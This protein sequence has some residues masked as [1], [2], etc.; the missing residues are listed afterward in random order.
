MAVIHSRVTNYNSKLVESEPKIPVYTLREEQT[1]KVISLLMQGCEE[2]G[3]GC[4]DGPPRDR[5]R[6][7]RHDAHT[8]HRLHQETH[9]QGTLLTRCL[10]LNSLSLCVT[11]QSGGF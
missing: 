10:E 6:T 11:T 7:R 8:G 3:E 4:A 2:H 1:S 9:D 5:R